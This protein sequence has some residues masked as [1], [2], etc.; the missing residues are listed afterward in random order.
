M[1]KFPRSIMASL[2]LSIFGL[3][4]ESFAAETPE[5]LYATLAKL[6]ADQRAKAHRR[7]GAQGG[8]A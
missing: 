1:L 2:L 6:P 5:Q 4:A 3:G 8:E 7:R